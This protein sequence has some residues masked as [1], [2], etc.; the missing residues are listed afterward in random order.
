MLREKKNIYMGKETF[1]TLSLWGF[2]TLSV[3]DEGNPR[4]LLRPLLLLGDTEV[5]LNII[6][7]FEIIVCLV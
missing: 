7:H 3:S 5:T 2:I 4:K 6:I 1:V